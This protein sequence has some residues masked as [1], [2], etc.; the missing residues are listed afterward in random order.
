MRAAVFLAELVGAFEATG[1][2]ASPDFFTV[3][4]ALGFSF[5]SATLDLPLERFTG[6][7]YAEVRL[8]FANWSPLS[9]RT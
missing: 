5:F 3:F 8:T 9:T 4:D 6:V 2:E 1:L 7:M